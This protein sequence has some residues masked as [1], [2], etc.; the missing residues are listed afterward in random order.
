MIQSS[1]HVDQTESH[2]VSTR[3]WMYLGAVVIGLSLMALGDPVAIEAEAPA[4]QAPESNAVS[5]E[6]TRLADAKAG[7]SAAPHRPAERLPLRAKTSE[8]TPLPALRK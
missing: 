2:C 7:K 5:Q 3:T 4:S 6:D 8:V 1:F